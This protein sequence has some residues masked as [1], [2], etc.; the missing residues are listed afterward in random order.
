VNCVERFKCRHDIVEVLLESSNSALLAWTECP[1]DTTVDEAM[2]AMAMDGACGIELRKA[3]C[4]AWCSAGGIEN[5]AFTD[6]TSFRRPTGQQVSVLELTRGS[7]GLGNGGVNA[8]AGTVLLGEKGQL[9]KVRSAQEVGSADRVMRLRTATGGVIL[10]SLDQLLVVE[11]Q[12]RGGQSSMSLSA[13]KIRS[14]IGPLP[15]LFDGSSMQSLDCVEI[16]QET[17]LV[18]EVSFESD[19]PVLAWTDHP[20]CAVGPNALKNITENEAPNCSGSHRY[21]ASGRVSPSDLPECMRGIEPPPGHTAPPPP[22]SALEPLLVVQATTAYCQLGPEDQGCAP[23]PKSPK[24]QD[25]VMCAWGTNPNTPSGVWQPVSAE[26]GT[27]GMPARTVGLRKDDLGTFYSPSDGRVWIS[28]CDQ[29]SA[30]RFAAGTAFRRPDGQLVS[31][32]QLCAMP[33]A[34][35]GG[36]AIALVGPRG[37]VARIRC[38]AAVGALQK[39]DFIRLQTSGGSIL[40]LPDQWVIVEGSDGS[41][42]AVRA[43]ELLG[44]GSIA[45]SAMPGPSIRVS[46]GSRFADVERVMRVEE[47]LQIVEVCFEECNG[48]MPLFAWTIQDLLPRAPAESGLLV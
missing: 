21:P 13:S 30:R 5:R 14:W 41:P 37:S 9:L 17:H 25:G 19:D 34:A 10:A 28:A 45:P 20:K 38:A 2:E 4:V 40:L 1:F 32:M 35:A 44:W 22:T 33:G 48:G 23:V 39:H 11:A 47:A 7:D 6:T 3:K 29:T 27:N 8:G 31:A 24:D 36:P 42:V 12:G 43:E 16:L 15:K 46:D 26:T 18:I